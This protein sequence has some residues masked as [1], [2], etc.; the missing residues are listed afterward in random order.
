MD[1]SISK[2]VQELIDE[3]LSL[4]CALNKGYGNY[5]AIARMLKPIVE[6]VL[7]RKV[8]LESVIT[9]VKRASTIYR[10]EYNRDIIEVIAKSIIHL[11]TD[12]AKISAEKTRK[13]LKLVRRMLEEFAHEE[14]VQIIE[15]MKTIT[16]I[17]DQRLTDKIR[18]EFPLENITEKKNNLVAIIITSPKKIIETPGCIV[19]FYNAISRKHINIE[20]TLSCSTETILV[21]QLKDVGKALTALTDLISEARIISRKLRKTQN[22]T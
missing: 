10:A 22:N 12:I 19:S 2:I 20:E 3:D 15:G 11:R 16:L 13:N 18:S 17:F 1:K 9:A 21:L 7:N 6:E 4:Q 14:Y 5:S 8:K